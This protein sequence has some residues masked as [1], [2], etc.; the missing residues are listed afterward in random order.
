MGVTFD[1]LLSKPL[2][3]KHKTGDIT[4]LDTTYLKLD[5]STPQETIGTFTFENTRNIDG[6]TITRDE[7]GNISKITYANDREIEYTRS[8][9]VIQSWTDGEYEWELQWTDDILTAV[10]VVEL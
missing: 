8:D 3:H 6:F 7:D 5:Q 9:G 10:N 2:L 4:G 1:K